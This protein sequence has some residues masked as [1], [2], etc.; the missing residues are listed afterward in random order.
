MNSLL[1]MFLTSLLGG[2]GNGDGLPPVTAEDEGK[3]LSVVGGKWV[4]T[5]LLN[6][7]EAS[8]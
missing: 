1:I 5:E 7:E 3:L 2:G 4:A 8:F 6:A